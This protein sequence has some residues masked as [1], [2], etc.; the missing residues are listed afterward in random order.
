MSSAFSE[1][2]PTMAAGVMTCPGSTE[3]VCSSANAAWS[4]PIWLVTPL[5]CSWSRLFR[6]GTVSALALATSAE[7]ALSW[8]LIWFW[9]RSVFARVTASE[10][11]LR[12]SR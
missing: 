4:W 6:A 10:R 12:K 3:P 7:S 1:L 5:I 2:R 11:A 9:M 8:L